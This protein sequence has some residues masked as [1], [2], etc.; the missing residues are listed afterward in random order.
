MVGTTNH[1]VGRA[2]EVGDKSALTL[3]VLLQEEDQGEHN[4]SQTYLLLSKLVL[5]FTPV[6]KCIL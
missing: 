2:P 3:S 6:F 5:T 1:D 4:T